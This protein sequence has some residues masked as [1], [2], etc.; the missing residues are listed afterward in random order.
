VFQ[1]IC[2]NAAGD[3]YSS[4]TIYGGPAYFIRN[5]FVAGV[6]MA[7]K[8]SI[9]PAGVLNINN[10]YVSEH[11]NMAAGSNIHFVNNLFVSHGAQGSKTGFGVNTFTNYSSSDYNGFYIAD[12]F[13]NKFSWTS[14]PPGVVADYEHRAVP[15]TF[16]T[17][18]DYAKATGQDTHSIMFDPAGFLRFRMPNNHDMSHLYPTDEY[19]LRLK[20]GSVAIDKGKILP[21]ITDNYRGSAPDIGAYE[22][23]DDLPHYGPRH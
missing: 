16:S 22:L 3:A 2:F 15:Q 1:N 18:A 5:V 17:L 23:G 14:P 6:G 9:T 12:S 20:R 4:Q 7:A 13:Q 21:N 19:D 8:L 10:T 11:Q